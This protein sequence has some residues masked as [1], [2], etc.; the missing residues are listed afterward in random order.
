ML[1]VQDADACS[2]FSGT[3][4]MQGLQLMPSVIGIFGGIFVKNANDDWTSKLF[5]GK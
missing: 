1:C 3:M 4:Q 5:G 2:G